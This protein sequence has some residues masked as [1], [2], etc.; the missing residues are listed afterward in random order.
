MY[1]AIDKAKQ[2]TKPRGFFVKHHYIS[3]SVAQKVIGSLCL[4]WFREGDDNSDRDPLGPCCSVPLP[5]PSA[6]SSLSQS[7]I[8]FVD[9]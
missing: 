4:I 3:L 9:T 7:I 6:I 5:L 2:S 8:L 1:L